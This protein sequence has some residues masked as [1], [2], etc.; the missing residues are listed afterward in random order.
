MQVAQ[1]LIDEG[2]IRL[3]RAKQVVKSYVPRTQM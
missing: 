3:E 2:N 1:Q